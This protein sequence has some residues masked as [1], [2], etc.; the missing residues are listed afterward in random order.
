[1]ARAASQGDAPASLRLRRVWPVDDS[2]RTPTAVLA[3]CRY[4]FDDER[5]SR[6]PS[7]RLEAELKRSYGGD[8]ALPPAAMPMR[9]P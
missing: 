2:T 4:R 5:V 7:S 1:M 8:G 3:L 6:L 9:R